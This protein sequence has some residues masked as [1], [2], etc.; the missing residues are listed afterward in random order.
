MGGMMGQDADEDSEE[1]FE[2][3]AVWYL[4]NNDAWQS[5]VPEDVLANV[6]AA[7]AQE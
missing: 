6:L 4:S 5:W 3:T 2:A 1:A 7:L